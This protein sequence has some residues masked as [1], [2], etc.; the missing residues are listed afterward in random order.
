MKE[1]KDKTM[2]PL[3]LN[4]AMAEQKKIKEEMEKFKL[5]EPIRDITISSYD[6]KK[7]VWLK[8]NVPVASSSSKDKNGEINRSNC[9]DC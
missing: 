5:D 7:N 4:E 9:S 1:R 3:N 8:K 2:L 6:A